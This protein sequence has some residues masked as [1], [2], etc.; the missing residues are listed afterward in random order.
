MK[1]WKQVATSE[2][3]NKQAYDALETKV[4]FPMR[5]YCFLLKN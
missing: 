1:T 5:K 4:M 3:Q 2:H